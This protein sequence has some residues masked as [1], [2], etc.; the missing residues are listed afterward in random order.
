[1]NRIIIIIIVLVILTSCSD[2]KEF[3]KPIRISPPIIEFDKERIPKITLK[4]YYFHGKDSSELNLQKITKFYSENQIASETDLLTSSNTINGRKTFYDYKG[5]I[6][7]QKR[8]VNAMEDSTKVVYFYNSKN[9]LVK[10]EHY[11]FKK[12]ISPEVIEK[13]RESSDMLLSEID[14]EENRSWDKYS[15][16]DFIYD[17][18]GQKTQ[19]YAPNLHWDNQNK[20]KWFYDENGNISTKQSWNHNELIWT[21]NYSYE[22][23]EYSFTRNWNNE[24]T[25]KGFK[26]YV[27][28]NKFGQKI[29]EV[30]TINDSIQNKR[31]TYEYYKNGMMK[32]K[33]VYGK[34]NE[35]LTTYIYEK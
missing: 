24:D 18:L 32:R 1:M 33:V 3:E 21:E 13:H 2:K 9:Q 23:N 10:R 14:F 4:E 7:V 35:R 25:Q 31:I 15:E 28:K 27:Y 22:N 17:S 12:R 11:T 29:K 6:L 26:F 30:T 16:I 8:T 5:S 20:Y 19:Y 34:N